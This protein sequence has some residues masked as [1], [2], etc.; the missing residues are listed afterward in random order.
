M[1]P[2]GCSPSSSFPF[3]LF[4]LFP[5]VIPVDTF[6]FR[7]SRFGRMERINAVRTRRQPGWQQAARRHPGWQQATRRH[8]G[9]QQAARRHPGRRRVTRGG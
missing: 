4:F 7:C 9:W 1:R 8:P 6:S 5:R 2:A 3:F